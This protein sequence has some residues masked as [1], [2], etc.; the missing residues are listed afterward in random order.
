M[1]T[2][3]GFLKLITQGVV[4]LGGV[5]ASP[6]VVLALAKESEE[7]RQKRL[8]PIIQITG[9]TNGWDGSYVRIK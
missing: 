8:N 1:K 6:T 9:T 4:V 5:C 7:E 3:R 2:R